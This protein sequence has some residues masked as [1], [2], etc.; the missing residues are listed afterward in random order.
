MDRGAIFYTCHLRF[1]SWSSSIGQVYTRK[2]KEKEKEKGK[3]M[4]DFEQM[5]QSL[6]DI[7]TERSSLYSQPSYYRE[8]YDQQQH[9]KEKGSGG[10]GVSYTVE[11]EIEDGAVVDGLDL[12]PDGPLGHHGGG[13][14]GEVRV[15]RRHQRAE[16]R[17]ERS[18]QGHPPSHTPLL[19]PSGKEEPKRSRGDEADATQS[20]RA[21]VCLGLGSTLSLTG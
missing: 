20:E 2:G 14:G 10:E 17:A 9:G 5:R 8:S 3:V 19:P 12:V 7:D 13:G 16:A 18:D 11:K 21:R 1:R 15:A 6:R 4:D